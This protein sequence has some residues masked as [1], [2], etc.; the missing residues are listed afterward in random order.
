MLL[1][2]NKYVSSYDPLIWYSEL[3]GPALQDLLPIIN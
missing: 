3:V 2:W 1:S